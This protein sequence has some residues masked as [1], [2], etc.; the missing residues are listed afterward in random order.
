MQTTN[1]SVILAI[2]SLTL[3][4]CEKWEIIDSDGGVCETC[5]CPQIDMTQPPMAPCAAAKGLAGDNLLCVDFDK[6]SGL[7]D[8]KLAAWNFKKDNQDCWEVAGG[9]LRIRN[10][11]TFMDRCGATL[12]PIDLKE[13]DKQRYSSV[14]L[15]I[16][17]K[18]DLNDPGQQAWIYLETDTASR[19]MFQTTGSRPLQTSAT[20][21]IN[22][23]KQEIPA[24]LSSVY[25]P[26]LKVQADVAV[27]N[28]LGWQI[29]SIAVQGIP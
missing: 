9:L 11:G 17:G 8:Q 2:V 20:I 19:L 16:V 6:V 26:Y 10:F 27:S 22:L 25:R 28:K 7:Q 3:A 4:G 15:S 21:L 13:A 14:T 1:C 23:P 24:A 12:P 5:K 29:S 18:I